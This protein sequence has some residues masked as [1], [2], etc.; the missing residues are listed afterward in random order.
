MNLQNSPQGHSNAG[1]I[2][3]WSMQQPEGLGS[4]TEA[5]DGGSG[6]AG[7][8]LPYGTFVPSS[9]ESNYNLHSLDQS[10]VGNDVKVQS[11]ISQVNAVGPPSV[12]PPNN[13]PPADDE[14]FQSRPEV[15]HHFRC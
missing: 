12:E 6:Y 13:F 10:S 9:E 1:A 15:T 5:D 11:P 3:P 7:V 14:D 8:P 2:T 4:D